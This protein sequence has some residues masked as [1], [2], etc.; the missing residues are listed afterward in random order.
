MGPVHGSRLHPAEVGPAVSGCEAWKENTT[1]FRRQ[2]WE[3]FGSNSAADTAR[4]PECGH[5]YFTDD[6]WFDID[7]HAVEYAEHSNHAHRR[8]K[9]L[10]AEL[11]ELWRLFNPIRTT[12]FELEEAIKA[13]AAL[14][15]M[16]WRPKQQPPRS[17][18]QIGRTHSPRTG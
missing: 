16:G 10:E 9:E 12:A 2:V 4:C 3:C 1:G 11:A 17:R 14:K 6:N 18:P 15:G 8:I 5:E 13:R 7:P